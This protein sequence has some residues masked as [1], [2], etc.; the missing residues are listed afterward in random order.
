MIIAS[1]PLLFALFSEERW[2]YTKTSDSNRRSPEYKMEELL[3][4]PFWSVSVRVIV[5]IKDVK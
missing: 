5:A 3:L 4:Q 2:K 1:F